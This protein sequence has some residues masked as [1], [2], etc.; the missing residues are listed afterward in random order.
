MTHTRRAGRGRRAPGACC[1]LLI[2]ASSLIAAQEK[3]VALEYLRPPRVAFTKFSA[4]IDTLVELHMADARSVEDPK[5]VGTESLHDGTIVN[6]SATEDPLPLVNQVM[7]AS[8]KG[9]GVPVTDQAD[10]VLQGRLLVFNVMVMNRRR[11][12]LYT[13]NVRI[14][15]DLKKRDGDLVWSGLAKGDVTEFGSL[16]DARAIHKTLSNALFGAY[17]NFFTNQGLLA[18][19]KGMVPDPPSQH[20]SSSDPMAASA[21]L[22]QLQALREDGGD[23]QAMLEQIGDKTLSAPLSPSDIAQWKTGGI[24][25]EVILAVLDV[26]VR[27]P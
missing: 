12:A 4:P 17:G 10:L 5:L 24:A 21:L 1:V 25:Q 6:V 27:S 14:A 23:V 16:N 8:A 9:L 13:G 15:F 2:A 7:L 26:P 18:A 19:T 20:R 22:R 3:S 11:D